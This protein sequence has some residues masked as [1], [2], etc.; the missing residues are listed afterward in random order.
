MLGYT[1]VNTLLYGRI[2]QILIDAASKAIT[3]V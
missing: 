2:S 1:K 3:I